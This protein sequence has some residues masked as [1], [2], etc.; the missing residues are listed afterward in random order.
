GLEIR[1]L[2]HFKE[3]S[4]SAFA[5]KDFAKENVLVHLS[6]GDFTFHFQ[7]YK[8]SKYHGHDE[9][10]IERG[11]ELNRYLTDYMQQYREH[12]TSQDSGNY[13]FL[14]SKGFPYSGPAFS[15]HL[16]ELFHR[17]T[18]VK[19]SINVLRSSFLTWAYGQP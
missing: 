11:S 5:L 17:L 9:V 6:S 12:L 18:G 7:A 3:T 4:Q 19:M 10:S 2:Q 1:T 13:V 8:T 16:K 15:S 14:N